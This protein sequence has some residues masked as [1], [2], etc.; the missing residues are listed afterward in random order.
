MPWSLRGRSFGFD[1]FA[2]ELR[3]LGIQPFDA[4]AGKIDMVG[5]DSELRIMDENPLL[6]VGSVHIVVV[7]VNSLRAGRLENNSSTPPVVSA[8]PCSLQTALLAAR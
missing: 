4:T 6:Y 5:V 3:L 7:L 8:G 1:V 2:C